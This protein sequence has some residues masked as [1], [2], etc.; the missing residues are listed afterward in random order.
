LEDH[1]D[2]AAQRDDVHVRV[3]NIDV[4]NA[5]PALADAGD[6]DKVVHAVKAPQ[7]RRLAATGRPD[8]GG[9]LVG[10]DLD[11]DVVHARDCP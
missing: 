4:V 9:D 5:N 3:M 6:I 2:L 10:R 11:V 7:Q 1:A 8:E